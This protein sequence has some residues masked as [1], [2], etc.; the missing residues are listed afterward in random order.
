MAYNWHDES[1]AKWNEMADYWN[2]SSESM[3]EKG[4]RKDIIPFIKRFV[5]P[6]S[7]IC[8]LGCGDGYGSLL[9][10]ASGYSVVG[11]DFADEMIQ[12]A[13]LR[14]KDYDLAFIHG[15]MTDTPFANEEFDAVMAINSIEWNE[16]PLHALTEMAR[17]TKP[18]GYACVGILGPTAAPR[19]NSY[20]RL[21]GKPAVC[22]TIMPWEFSQLAKENGWIV[23]DQFPV[24]KREVESEWA[25]PLPPILQQALSFMWVFMLQKNS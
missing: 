25:D 1:Q 11:I 7:S 14:I 16:S 20:D 22:H 13:K 3:W 18:K 19:V 21:Y 2:Q 8:D 10:A 12:K 4:S 17:I 15:S 5:H 23:A 9:L 24:Y 6:G